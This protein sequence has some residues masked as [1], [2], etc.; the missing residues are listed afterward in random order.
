MEIQHSLTAS[1][2]AATL[3][4][5]DPRAILRALKQF[6]RTVRR[7][8]RLALSKEVDDEES[9]HSDGDSVDEELVEEPPS[10]KFKKN[11]Q[12]K[13][14][15]AS[16]HVPF[17]GTSVAKGEAAKVV[18]GQWPTGLLQAY[19]S[20][21]PLATE[22]ISDDLNAPDGQIHKSLIRKKQNKTSRSIQKQY[23][24]ALAELVTAEIPIDNLEDGS[25]ED[26]YPKIGE[27]D[28]SKHD[29]FLP[30]FL[31][32]RLSGLFH[33][34]NEETDKGRGKPGVFGGCGNLVEPVLKV[35]QNIA[36]ISVTY[37]RLVARH[38]DESL[39]DGVLK[40]LLRPFPPRKDDSSD[41]IN[42]KVRSKKARVEAIVLA[43][44]LIH[45][46]D[47]AVNTYICTSGS[48]ERKVKPGILYI[49]F[50]E[51]LLSKEQGSPAAESDDNYTEAVEQMI[52]SFRLLVAS[53]SR[54]INRKLL[55][56]LIAKD[57]LQNLCHMIAYAPPL[58]NGNT[59]VDV[60]NAEDS[61]AEVESLPY[62]A[63]EARR[64]LLQ[65]LSG[66]SMPPLFI[67]PEQ[68]QVRAL[69]QLLHVPNGGIQMHHFIID[70]TAKQPALLSSLF[71]ML[72]FPDPNKTF[73][74]VSSVHFV[75]SLIR[76]G[77]SPATC[78]ATTPYTTGNPEDVLLTLF[79]IQFKRQALARGLQS[80]NSLI[81]LESLK[82]LSAV[83]NRFELLKAEGSEQMKWSDDYISILSDELTRWLP[84]MQILLK[85]KAR[86]DAFSGKLDYAMLNH[87]LHRTIERFATVLP[88]LIREAFPFVQRSV[89]R[90]LKLVVEICESSSNSI[91][92]SCQTILE[93]MLNT[94]SE[95]IHVECRELAIEILMPIMQSRW[96]DT[97]CS[98]SINLIKAASEDALQTVAMIGEVWIEC[99][100]L[101]AVE[102]SMFLVASWTFTERSPSFSLLMAQ[103]SLKA[104]LFHRSPLVLAKF[105]QLWS[106]SKKVASIMR[107]PWTKSVADYS[108]AICQYDGELTQAALLGEVL[109][110]LFS[111]ADRS[112]VTFRMLNSPAKPLQLLKKIKGK[113]PFDHAISFIRFLIHY[114]VVSNG[115]GASSSRCWLVLCQVVPGLLLR[116]NCPNSEKSRLLEDLF[117]CN[118][119][120]EMLGFI[121]A[122]CPYT[123]E[124]PFTQSLIQEATSSIL[125][126]DIPRKKRAMRLAQFSV[127]CNTNAVNNIVKVQL[128]LV[129]DLQFSLMDSLE[130]PLDFIHGFTKATCSCV[131]VDA[132]YELEVINL[133]F[134]TWW[135][136][137]N[138]DIPKSSKMED[139]IS[140]FSSILTN[141]TKKEDSQSAMIV[142][143]ARKNTTD[144]IFV[145]CLKPTGPGKVKRQIAGEE[146]KLL[147]TLLQKDA[148]RLTPRFIDNFDGMSALVKPMWEHGHLDDLLLQVLGQPILSTLQESCLQALSDSIVT[149]AEIHGECDLADA[150]KV[151]EL[152]QALLKLTMTNYDII[153]S[154]GLFDKVSEALN[155]KGLRQNAAT[156]SLCQLAVALLQR[157]DQHS[158]KHESSRDSSSRLAS[159]LLLR[160]IEWL[161][162]TYKTQQATGDERLDDNVMLS[163]LVILCNIRDYDLEVMRTLDER[164]IL[165]AFRSCLKNGIGQ[166][167]EKPVTASKSLQLVRELGARLFDPLPPFSLLK[168]KW[169]VISLADIFNMLTAHSLFASLMSANSENLDCV[170]LEALRLMVFCVGRSPGGIVMQNDVWAALFEAFNAGLGEVDTAIRK[171]FYVSFRVLSE[172]ETV[173][174]PF[175]DQI[176]WKGFTESRS[177]QGRRW[178][179]FI[180]A[181]D[182]NRIRSTISHFPLYDTVEVDL[183]RGGEMNKMSDDES[184]SQSSTAE[185]SS[186]SEDND[187]A[188]DDSTSSRIQFQDSLSPGFQWDKHGQD[189]RYSPAFLLPFF[190]GALESTLVS[191]HTS[192][193]S[194][195][196]MSTD[197]QESTPSSKDGNQYE[198]LVRI[199]QQLIDKGAVCLCLASLSSKCKKVRYYALSVLS[200]LLTACNSTEAKGLSSWRGRPQVAM[201]LNS[202]Q[203]AFA[204]K[205][206]LIKSDGQQFRLPALSPLVSTFLARASLSICKPDDAMYVPLNR[207]FLKNEKDHGAFADMNRLPGFISLFCSSSEDLQQA[208]K[209]RIWALQLL[210]DG[211]LDASCYRLVAACHAPEL[212]LTAFGN[213]RLSEVSGEMKDAEFALLLNVVAKIVLFGSDRVT[214]H[215]VSR[216]GLISWMRSWCTSRP[217]SETFPGVKSRVAFCELVCGVVKSASK[218]R[219]LRN[220]TFLHEVCGLFQP[221]VRL[222]VVDGY[223][224][225]AF[226]LLVQSVC[227]A[228]D[229]VSMVTRQLSEDDMD[230]ELGPLGV[231]LGT[232]IKFLN[233]LNG[234]QQ[235]KAA[236]SFC[237]LPL[238]LHNSSAN[239]AIE[240]VPIL[241]GSCLCSQ[242]N[243][244][245]DVDQSVLILKRVILIGS[246]FGGTLASNSRALRILLG[247]RSRFAS[248]TEQLNLYNQCLNVL[249]SI[250]ADTSEEH[251]IARMLLK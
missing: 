179:W 149:R 225:D 196:E 103:V 40:C 12:W 127:L 208:R 207:Y 178:D 185:Y 68:Q 235:R 143:L 244:D 66:S 100:D 50:R 1:E 227:D 209:E 247:M 118:R 71:R 9:D 122:S 48:R 230:F 228:I 251:L 49:A 239:E 140:Q 155:V 20:K 145:R 115:D 77:P 166:S 204:I 83:I 16:Y 4:G 37:A 206:A 237:S 246:R 64:L 174:L 231:S 102:F 55:L 221:L 144:D 202:I 220:D 91:L 15:S 54:S 200:L 106:E 65:L 126:K 35:L 136:L 153:M 34:L 63:I 142:A 60:L 123:S 117:I 236:A 214:S 89:L 92:R 51:G 135:K 61:Y 138:P 215:L 17:V 2:F 131:S 56:D 105:I 13:E 141:V 121:V 190:L 85:V 245:S 205:Q 41:S 132:T 3:N 57:P 10:K 165:K 241:L 233:A 238:S 197:L 26:D 182:L 161:P 108:K 232:C 113:R 86:F 82:L 183:D 191:L 75:S 134:G 44:K 193:S 249:A 175:L 167:R 114:F 6:R 101:G 177:Q 18:R 62:A 80:G 14:D 226:Q 58:T 192:R 152:S 224:V 213:V 188:D 216:V 28:G 173:H 212:V 110:S 97:G 107:S 38:L 84:D 33:I 31:K 147:G 148:A 181:L 211:F 184:D 137:S 78:L 88:T 176:R 72:K 36:S 67:S 194:H 25:S 47:S 203:R 81:V 43:T 163:W 22:L 219:K 8:R 160:C 111:G 69:I 120:D 164:L 70:C 198:L 222:G 76:R 180:D 201:L 23:L 150:R 139:L 29:K 129:A 124:L 79:P 151:L 59:F 154:V 116:K 156:R 234:T 199:A 240:L 30:I 187:S 73:D 157:F 98:T 125:S 112:L 128:S 104:I 218:D 158:H 119:H 96:T 146:I 195:I 169:Q 27:Q 248:S 130:I 210:R 39:S 45:T 243:S 93:I 42:V 162:Y 7:E 32:K 242:S 52:H 5:D 168:E 170:K 172:S 99:R 189:M 217:L 250:D 109:D 223:P 186:S 11:E 46:R 21:S 95:D 94:K 90:T 171:L 159:R 229:A 133:L 24:L 87:C 74:F 19:L 53:N